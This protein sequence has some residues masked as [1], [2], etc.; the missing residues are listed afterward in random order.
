MDTSLAED[1]Q[2]TATT[3]QSDSFFFMSP[4]RSFTT[5]GCFARFAE[6]AVGGDDPAGHFQQKLAQAFGHAKASGI[7]HPIMVG[8]IPFDTRKPSSLFIPQRWQTFSRPA[9]Q[10]SSRYFSGA[11]TLNVEKRTEIPAQPVFEEMV[12]RAA[13]LTATPQVNKV[14]LSR[15]IDIETDK[16]ID[17]GALLE[18]L[19]AQ[20]P[21][22]FNFHVPL[23]DGGVLL[24]ASPELLLR[25]EGAHFSS[26]PL[27]G[28]ALRQPDDVLDREA[29][30]KL[31]ASEKDRH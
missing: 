5:S 17:S 13:A 23:E 31:L 26:L 30:N 21:A 28:S 9:R 4:Y 18:R 22:S 14:V 20:N 12:A 6:S 8:A 7:A 10:Q 27:A 19:I 24:G 3:L 29:G 2:H 1:I 15:L 11:Q 25:K 16:T